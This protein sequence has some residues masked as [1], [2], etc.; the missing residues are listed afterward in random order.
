ME[1]EVFILMLFTKCNLLCNSDMN[2][3]YVQ[4]YGNESHAFALKKC[5]YTLDIKFHASLLFVV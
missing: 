4:M 2:A 3:K 1:N 5:E